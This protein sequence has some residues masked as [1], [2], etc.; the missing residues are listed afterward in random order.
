MVKDYIKEIEN[1]LLSAVVAITKKNVLVLILSN[2]AVSLF[3]LLLLLPNTL[4]IF[5]NGIVD[6]NFSEI[7]S[8]YGGYNFNNYCFIFNSYKHNYTIGKLFLH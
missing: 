5:N 3:T 2:A 8:L 4:N 1:D 6:N 7:G